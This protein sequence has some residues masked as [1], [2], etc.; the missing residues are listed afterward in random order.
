[1]P[2]VFSPQ[3]FGLR[4]MRGGAEGWPITLFQK[5]PFLLITLFCIFPGAF[6][7][8][9]FEKKTNGDQKVSLP[10]CSGFFH[11][12]FAMFSVQNIFLNSKKIGEIFLESSFQMAKTTR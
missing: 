4:S 9:I 2:E 12:S 5:G 10:P 3:V 8:N 7:F 1:M 6:C 11:G